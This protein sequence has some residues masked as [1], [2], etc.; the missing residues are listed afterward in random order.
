MCVN[1]CT[2]MFFWTTC[3]MKDKYALI[4][5]KKYEWGIMTGG[6]NWPRNGSSIE[7]LYER[8]I[9]QDTISIPNMKSINLSIS[10]NFLV[11][12]KRNK[13]QSVL[14]IWLDKYHCSLGLCFY[15]HQLLVFSLEIHY[16]KCNELCHN[17]ASRTLHNAIIATFTSFNLARK[18]K[19][20][21][22]LIYHILHIACVITIPWYGVTVTF[23]LNPTHVST[24]TQ[25]CYYMTV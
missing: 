6:E 21:F 10:L 3:F 11:T 2:N 12:T 18:W 5:N 16:L 24:S 23:S 7:H 4:V 13:Q 20:H 14:R 15:T 25:S 22:R 9:Q 1:L 17:F 19:W 8:H